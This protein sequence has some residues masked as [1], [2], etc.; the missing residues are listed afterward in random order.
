MLP[1]TADA[2]FPEE[3]SMM[4]DIGT[5]RSFRVA[6]SLALACVG[7]AAFCADL[8][9]SKDPPFKRFAGSEIVGYQ[10]KRFES[11]D[12]QSSTFKK[13]DLKAKRRD[14]AQPPLKVE[15]ALTQVWYE[16]PGD[17]SST[18]LIRNYQNELLSK[19][20]RILYDSTKDPAATVWTNFLA[21]FSQWDIKT[22]RSYYI[23]YAADTK[24]IRVC[25]AKLQRPEGDCYVFLT[26]V[27]WPKDDGIYKAKRGAYIAVDFIETHAMAQNMVTVSA[28]EMSKSIAETGRVALYGIYF[29][30]NKADLKPESKAALDEIAKLL[31]AE[32]GLRLH[33]VGHT[34][35]A[36]GLE[37]NLGLSKRR[38]DAVAAALVKDCGIA[39]ARLTANGVA[40]LAPV[41]S[42][43]TEE[44]RAK[45]RRVELVPQ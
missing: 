31:K 8:P 6:V 16:S 32:P 39:P 44:G 40:Y 27:E 14:Y 15:G 37:F 9:G 17:T 24:G 33:V 3:G 29:D 25:S 1:Y 7:A 2:F 19:G 5:A 43:A 42:N 23:F 45:N 34:D 12:L 18:E 21:S 28:D 36:G 26:A 20:Y 41:A 22:S 10:V 35:N 4:T 38:A 13:Y 30:T 11:Y